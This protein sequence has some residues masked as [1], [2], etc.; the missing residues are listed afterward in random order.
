M[1]PFHK[2]LW[3]LVTILNVSMGCKHYVYFCRTA[4]PER[5]QRV[6]AVPAAYLSGVRIIPVSVLWLLQRCAAWSDDVTRLD[7]L[8]SV[9]DVARECCEYDNVDQS[10]CQVMISTILLHVS[11]FCLL[12]NKVDKELVRLS[13]PL[14]SSYYPT[15]SAVNVSHQR[16]NSVWTYDPIQRF[17]QLGEWSSWSSNILKMKYRSSKLPVGLIA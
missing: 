7:A 8:F 1:R 10:L 3:T 6:H 14:P 13:S 9:A 11:V 12:W 15:A 4:E 17:F 2:L 16:L 5:V